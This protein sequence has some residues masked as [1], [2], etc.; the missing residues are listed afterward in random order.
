MKYGG[1]D[2]VPNQSFSWPVAFASVWIIFLPNCLIS[3]R[4]IASQLFFP[5][6]SK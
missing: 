6:N 1:I 2:F 4:Y 3:L 5:T